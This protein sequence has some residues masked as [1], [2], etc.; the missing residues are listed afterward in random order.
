M[1]TNIKFIHVGFPKCG[2]TFLQSEVFDKI[3]DINA[4]TVGG[5]NCKLPKCLSYM[6]YC[7]DPYFS[8]EKVAEELK[9]I[10]EEINGISNE[11]FTSFVSPTIMA[12]RLH[13]AFG[14]TKI[15]IVL[16]N[17]KSILLS[18]YLHD[19]KIGYA[20][21]FEKWLKRLFNTL[22]YQSFMYSHTINAYNKQFGKE[23]V[24]VVLFEELFNEKAII[25]I[26]DFIGISGENLKEIKY[27]LKVN[28]AYSPWSLALTR[29]F[30]RHF[31]TKENQRAGFLY[32]IYRYRIVPK[33][34]KIYAA[35]GGKKKPE[36]FN[37]KMMDM[38]AEWY[39]DDNIAL[40]KILNRDLSEK[41]YR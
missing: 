27:D 39:H 23:N 31:G 3:K 17:Q 35:L 13:Q 29:K 30:N 24:K 14:D 12:N 40:G 26:L 5:K 28:P 2:S 9:E 36:Y 15:L 10:P 6:T 22:R 11:G 20:L 7:Q 19:I 8:P 32:E 18:H 1:T 41:G 38:I 37:D 21:S 25:E 16:R 34:D 4:I 33:I